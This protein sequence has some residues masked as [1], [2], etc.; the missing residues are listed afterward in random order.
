MCI[1]QA[2]HFWRLVKEKCSATKIQQDDTNFGPF[3]KIFQKFFSSNFY[4]FSQIALQRKLGRFRYGVFWFVLRF[5][6]TG[7]CIVS[8]VKTFLARVYFSD[9]VFVPGAVPTHNSLNFFRCAGLWF[10][11]NR[12]L[13]LFSLVRRFSQAWSICHLD[14]LDF[15]AS[16]VFGREPGFPKAFCFY[17]AWLSRLP[18]WRKLKFYLLV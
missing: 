8:I 11:F 12:N 2:G 13:G 6:A 7:W 17:S 3:P 14:N 16:T 18:C 10:F 15:S 1:Y 9:N 5:C 4:F